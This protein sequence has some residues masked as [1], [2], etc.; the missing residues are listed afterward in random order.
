MFCFGKIV[1]IVMCLEGENVDLGI[2]MNSVLFYV[3]DKVGLKKGGVSGSGLV[4][5]K[6]MFLLE[7]V[8][9]LKVVVW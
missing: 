5:I 7:K 4:D 1:N 8:I 6:V 2:L 9:D 3:L